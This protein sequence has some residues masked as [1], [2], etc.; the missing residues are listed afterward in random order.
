MSDV[1][2]DLSG[3]KSP[4]Y[5]SMSMSYFREGGDTC[6]CCW[7][8]HIIYGLRYASQNNMNKAIK[9]YCSDCGKVNIIQFHWS[10]TIESTPS[11]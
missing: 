7:C 10:L 5:N 1:K 9:K 11:R 2:L 6:N 8:G 3:D 4:A